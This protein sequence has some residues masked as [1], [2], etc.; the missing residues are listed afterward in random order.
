MQIRSHTGIIYCNAV[1]PNNVTCYDRLLRTSI[2]CCFS[3]VWTFNFYP[4]HES[5]ETKYNINNFPLTRLLFYYSYFPLYYF[6]LF[7]FFRNIKSLKM[8]KRENYKVVYSIF[9]DDLLK[10]F[11]SVLIIT[12]K[13]F[14]IR[15]ASLKVEYIPF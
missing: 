3:N 11:L 1:W 10:T 2:H 9:R 14:G 8:M 13:L 15:Y 6:I 7:Y 12:T 4:K 5:D